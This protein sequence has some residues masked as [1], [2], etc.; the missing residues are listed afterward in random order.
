MDNDEKQAKQMQ[1]NALRSQLSSDVSDI[2]DWKIT[3]I[4]EARMSNEADPYDF[5]A[6]ATARQAVRDKINSLQVGE[7]IER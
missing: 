6:L 1:I 2:G 5:K 7:N 4:Y 3:K